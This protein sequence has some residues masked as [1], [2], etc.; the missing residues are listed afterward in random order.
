ML[1]IAREWRGRQS[2]GDVEGEGEGGNTGMGLCGAGG[3]SNTLY[4]LPPVRSAERASERSIVYKKFINLV[5]CYLT[6]RSLLYKFADQ[7]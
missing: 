1:M 3:G 4:H 6:L 7:S 5:V 2:E